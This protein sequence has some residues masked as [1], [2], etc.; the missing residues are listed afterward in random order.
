M[1]SAQFFQEINFKL[2]LLPV[3]S[4]KFNRIPEL[5]DIIDAIQV[6]LSSIIT[7]VSNNAKTNDEIKRELE[8]VQSNLAVSYERAKK[9]EAE[10]KER[11]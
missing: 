10:Q 9:L 8:N 3:L 4:Q 11:I 7:Q 2:D 1:Q 6:Q 5:S